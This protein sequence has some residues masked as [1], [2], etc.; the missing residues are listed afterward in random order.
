MRTPG[1]SPKRRSVPPRVR[2]HGP[3][4]RL[5]EGER[6]GGRATAAGSVMRGGTYGADAQR[7]WVEARHCAASAAWRPRSG[8]GPAPPSAA[9]R[10]QLLM[11]GANLLRNLSPS[12]PDAPR[13]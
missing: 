13:V 5:R 8:T 10:M 1:G 3:I 2:T 6:A 11:I 7:A 4:K 9:L 12:H